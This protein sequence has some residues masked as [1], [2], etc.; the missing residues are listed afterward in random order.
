MTVVK[1]KWKHA[2]NLRMRDGEMVVAPDAD[3]QTRAYSLST[4]GKAKTRARTWI[5][6]DNAFLCGGEVP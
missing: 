2:T 1:R 5:L 6:L 4:N 3:T